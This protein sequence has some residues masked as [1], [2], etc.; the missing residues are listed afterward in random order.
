MSWYHANGEDRSVVVS[1]RIRLARNLDKV[2]FPSRMSREA[3]EE[4]LQKV[5]SAVLDR[6]SGFTLYKM[7]ELSDIEKRAL[8]EAHLISAELLEPSLAR[9]VLLNEDRTVSIMINEEDHVRLQV[10][11]PG[12]QPEA[13]W[14]TADKMD[15]LLGE[16]LTFAFHEKMGYLASCPTNVGTGMRA[17]AM[18][19]L[20]ALTLTGSL[21]NLLNSVGKLGMTVRGLYGEGTEAQG[22]FY[23][24]SNQRTLGMT[25]EE[26]LS[27]FTSV[28][29]QLMEKEQA[30]R[31]RIA[32][33]GDAAV[34]DR[35]SRAYGL[36]QNAYI[37]SGKEFMNLYSD[38]RLGQDLG[39][40]PKASAHQDELLV[41]TQPAS[42]CREEKAMLPAARRDI[43]RAERVRDLLK[44]ADE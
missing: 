40:L 20:P 1:T 33:S 39:F 21:G 26:L 15:T 23:Q 5:A 27:R 3:S 38:V 34:R 22:N 28:I 8:V 16:S 29:R 32:E 10:I 35:V 25:E 30:V 18:I 31:G 14:E 17:S 41:T 12:F 24:I 11:L 2:P 44:G 6:Q 43:L 13:A 42:L 19:H 9:G 4:V 37:L 7:A 36:L